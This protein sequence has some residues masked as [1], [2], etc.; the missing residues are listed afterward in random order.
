MK[1]HTTLVEFIIVGFSNDHHVNIILLVVLS[2]VFLLTVVG[3]IT[4]VTL[5]FVD[6]RLQ[7]PM[8]FFLRNFSLLEI[9]FSF[10]IMPRFLYSLLTERKS[11]SVPGCFLQLLLFFLLGSCIFFHVGMMSF[12]RYM[13]ICRPLHYGT[14]MNGRVCF[15]LVLSCWVMSFF[16]MFP[17]AFMAVL[18]PFCGPN[19]IN[20]FYCDTAALLQLSCMDT[21]HIEIMI[22]VSTSVL[23]LGNFTVTV[24]SYGCIITTIMCIPSTTGRKKAF[25][26]CSAHLLVV[27]ILYSS[28]I[29][30]YVRPSQRGARDFDKF[31]AFFFSVVAQMLNPYIYALRNEQVKQALKDACGRVLSKCSRL[32]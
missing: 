24:I 20:H 22:L 16:I 9:C 25:S 7:S 19:V 27:V 1:N 14:I 23:I 8:Y 21:G 10:V 32:S 26:T 6:H 29:F 4:V 11:I 30:R 12:D 3:N 2:A 31:V 5:S 17:P 28:S 13:A 18:V 15:Q